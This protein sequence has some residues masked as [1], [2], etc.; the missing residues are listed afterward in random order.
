MAGKLFNYHNNNHSKKKSNFTK[1]IQHDRIH[2]MLIIPNISLD[3][4]QESLF[5][6]LKKNNISSLKL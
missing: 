4:N 2:I 1:C 3:F 5:T 6:I